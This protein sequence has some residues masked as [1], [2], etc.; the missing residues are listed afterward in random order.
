MAS[1]DFDGKFVADRIVLF[2]SKLVIYYSPE[3]EPGDLPIG[4]KNIGDGFLD[5]R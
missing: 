3:E 2:E 1:T 4:P 5:F